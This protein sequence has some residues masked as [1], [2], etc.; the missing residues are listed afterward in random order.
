MGAIAAISSFFKGLD[1]QNHPLNSACFPDLI[2]TIVNADDVDFPDGTFGF[3]IIN[4]AIAVSVINLIPR[5]IAG[6]TNDNNLTQ[7][8]IQAGDAYVGLFIPGDFE[9]IVMP[10]G[11]LTIMVFERRFRD[12]K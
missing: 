9:N 5:G 7:L 10:V 8:T 3:M 4:K 6:N 12:Y 2:K 1:I 11:T